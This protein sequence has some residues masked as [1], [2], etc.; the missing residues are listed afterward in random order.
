MGTFCVN[1][2]RL[3]VAGGRDYADFL[4]LEREVDCYLEELCR[5]YPEKD[6]FVIVSGAA[7]GAAA[8]GK[9]YAMAHGL[10]CAEYPAKWD[11]HGRSAG[12][13]R[14]SLM[15]ENAHGC[16]CFWDGKS[17]GTK[18]MIEVAKYKGLDVMTI[19]Y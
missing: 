14:N 4:E 9:R 5:K 10:D 7:R 3:I 13:K 6:T 1:V 17:K 2:Y 19:R 11:L 18:H 16:I 12:Y 8:L 15:A